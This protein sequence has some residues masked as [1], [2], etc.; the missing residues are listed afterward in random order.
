MSLQIGDA[1]KDGGSQ[2]LSRAGATL[3]VAYLA[4]Y[5]VYQLGFNGLVN[6]LYARLDVPTTSTQPALGVS[7]AVNGVLLLVAML[8][9]LYVT[10]VAVRTFVARERDSIPGAFW[11]DG[12]PFAMANLFVGGIVLNVAVTVGSL[13]FLVP[14]IFLY[15]SLL[16]MVTYVAAENE[17]F[18][19]A[20]KKSWSLTDGERWSVFGLVLALTVIG[21]VVGIVFGIVGVVA[22]FA[23]GS[24]AFMVVLTVM[25]APLSLFSLA[26]VAAAFNQLRGASGEGPVTGTAT[27]DT[28]STP[29]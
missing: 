18:V 22:M 6:V 26:V 3:T 13:F 7:P 15:V 19:A 16:F 1:V 5:I 9:M 14:G 4:V 21:F 27:P 17:N 29:A 10:V 20:L 8:A 28:S 12:V 2:L 23:L 24:A 25:I 11:T